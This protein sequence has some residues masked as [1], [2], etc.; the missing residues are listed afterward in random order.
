MLKQTLKTKKIM[1]Y[2][3]V[4]LVAIAM[5]MVGCSGKS[6][7]VDGAGNADA[8]M[9]QYNTYAFASQVDNK[10]DEGLFFVND[11]VLKAE[12]RD[13]VKHELESRGYRHAASGPD[14]VVN[15]RVFDKATQIQG[16]QG[17]GDG[18]WSSAETVGIDAPQTVNL[19]K[20]SLMI[21]IVDRNTGKLVWQGYASGLMDGDVFSKEKNK[22]AEA[23]SMIFESY[24]HRA[25]KL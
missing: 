20:G 19:E 5:W 11:L 4:C 1:K 24:N 6:Y 2:L 14:L 25:D 15:F 8:N 22:V 13:A 9:E 10:L 7:K 16:L 12:I 3:N 17:L 23:V 18:Y 21:H